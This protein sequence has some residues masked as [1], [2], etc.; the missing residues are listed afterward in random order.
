MSKECV[1]LTAC[2][3]VPFFGFWVFSAGV[4]RHVSRADVE[5]WIAGAARDKCSMP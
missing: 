5:V 2:D 1:H 3:A 4:A